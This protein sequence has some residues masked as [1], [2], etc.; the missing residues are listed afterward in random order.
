GGLGIG[1]LLSKNQD[2]LAFTAPDANQVTLVEAASATAPGKPVNV[3][4]TAALGASTVVPIDAGSAGKTGL[5]DMYIGSIYNSPDANL[6]TIL[7]N[8][9]S[10]YPKI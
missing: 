5:M 7:R 9:G 2:G 4:F 1:H 8:D 6:A 3:P 10:E